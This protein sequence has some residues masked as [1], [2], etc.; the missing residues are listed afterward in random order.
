MKKLMIALATGL[1][2]TMA[3]AN[4]S[5][6]FVDATADN[7]DE[8]S[9]TAGVG[10]YATDG[11]INTLRGQTSGNNADIN[12]VDVGGIGIFTRRPN[13][14]SQDFGGTGGGTAAYNGTPL[15]GFVQSFLA[16]PETN[17][18]HVEL[19]NLNQAYADGYKI[20]AYVNGDSTANGGSITVNTGVNH[21]G[22]DRAAGETYYFKTRYTSAGFATSG[23]V[24]SDY[25]TVQP[26]AA[27]GYA[28][29]DYVVFDNLSADSLTLTVQADLQSK[30]GLGGFQIVAIPEPATLGFMGIAGSGL[31]FLRKRFGSNS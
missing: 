29:A 11:W 30:V 18:G 12:S 7:N 3:Q 22:Y 16:N 28:V 20:V 13:G 8:I 23:Y 15:K 19:S 1:F 31:L 2:V 17:A 25:Q 14:T 6:N 10:A 24:E 9:G 21:T 27:S 4:V 5:V 26:S